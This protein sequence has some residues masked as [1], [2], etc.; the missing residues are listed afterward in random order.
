[1]LFACEDGR[2]VVTS[3]RKSRVT[4]FALKKVKVEDIQWDPNSPN[5]LL[6][7]W[8]DGSMS[9]LDIETEK[10]MQVFERQGAGMH[11]G[12]IT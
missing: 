1:M 12:A 2:I 6:A 4:K 5:Y 3:I 7:A 10:E 9:L 8:K 11:Y